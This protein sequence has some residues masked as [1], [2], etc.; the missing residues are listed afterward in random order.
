MIDPQ[1]IERINDAAKIEDVVSDYVT[2]RRRGANLIGL[3]PFHN[4]KTP[5]FNVNPARNIFKCFGCAKGGDSVHFVMEIEQMSYPD[6]LR[7][8]AKKYHIEIQERELSAEEKAEQTDRES[9][10]LVNE[11]AGK[12]FAQ[13]LHQH[14]EGKAIGL[15]YFHERGFRDDIITKFQL[16]YSLDAWD[17][18][19]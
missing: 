13:N 11:F 17:D 6:A 16:G 18:L 14:V 8:L 1:T 10:L 15:S 4:E 9:M 7:L 19:A 12:H 2:L 3:C 5:S